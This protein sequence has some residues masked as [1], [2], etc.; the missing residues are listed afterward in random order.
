M[1]ARRHAG[2]GPV[3]NLKYLAA[4]LF[5]SGAIEGI[6]CFL[7]LQ[8]KMSSHPPADVPGP[9][10][11]TALD[12]DTPMGSST[13]LTFVRPKKDR[14]EAR[15]AVTVPKSS[16][17]APP[18]ATPLAERINA[19]K[20]HTFASHQSPFPVPGTSSSKTRALPVEHTTNRAFYHGGRG[21]NSNLLAEEIRPRTPERTRLGRSFRS[22]DRLRLDPTNLQRARSP[23]LPPP[24]PAS[25]TRQPQ[26]A[27]ASDC[28]VNRDVPHNAE[29]V[30]LTGDSGKHALP[31]SEEQNEEQNVG[32]I[33]RSDRVYTL[34]GLLAGV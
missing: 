9:G 16:T 27:D 34:D 5:R 24:V 31:E 30:T 4:A 10:P 7:A 32:G 1:N 25:A 20:P 13:A 3:S 26:F 18:D 33:F 14:T 17:D 19:N 15:P 12:D 8:L 23:M 29:V 6:S 11:T 28:I 22:V 2:V 21:R